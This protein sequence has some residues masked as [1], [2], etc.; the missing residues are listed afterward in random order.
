[1][2]ANVIF[3]FMILLAG[4]IWVMLA[5][6]TC[7]MVVETAV[8][9][10]GLHLA[11]D[12]IVWRVVL[13]NLVSATLGGFIA[14]VAAAMLSPMIADPKDLI[15]YCRSFVL[16]A[17]V[18]YFLFFV[19]TVFLEQW[20]IAIGLMKTD[21]GIPRGRILR[22]VL[23]ANLLSYLVA[24]P[25]HYHY[26]RPHRILRSIS[27]DVSWV[28]TPTSR[29]FYV[30]DQGLHAI[31]SDGSDRQVMASGPVEHYLISAD[32][33][34][35]VFWTDGREVFYCDQDAGRQVK[36]WE[37]ERTGDDLIG[38]SYRGKLSTAKLTAISRN[39]QWVAWCIPYGQGEPDFWRV[40]AFDTLSETLFEEN[41]RACDVQ[42]CWS[43]NDREFYMNCGGLPYAEKARGISGYVRGTIDRSEK[44][45]T[46]E[47]IPALDESQICDSYGRIGSTR[48]SGG[49][50]DAGFVEDQCGE[51]SVHVWPFG[52]RCTGGSDSETFYLHDGHFLNPY[53][54]TSF[55]EALF[56]SNGREIVFEAKGGLYLM[57]ICKKKAGKLI[58]GRC[59]VVPTDTCNKR[60]HFLR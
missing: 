2:L 35:C 60:V 13:A 51:T 53:M 55:R 19:I 46:L 16:V 31:S 30:D 4:P 27:E 20:I 38:W 36:I 17:A 58:E 23:L 54:L 18:C 22:V 1:M 14:F 52:L 3:P 24:V 41:F 15:D 37:S 28:E 29:V 25:V 32:L 48:L 26:N 47:S 10:R 9:S 8:C 56:L 42:I 34:H 45:I 50:I 57:D 7:C 6:I 39:G 49:H 12:R 40:Y 44:R 5:V 43:N 59:M 33:K 21:K 11:R